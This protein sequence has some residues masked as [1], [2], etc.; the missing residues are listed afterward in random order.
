MY[1]FEQ[2][3]QF[4]AQKTN[5][6]ESPVQVSYKRFFPKHIYIHLT[7]QFF[8]HCRVCSLVASGYLT[9]K[10]NMR[11]QLLLQL[12]LCVFL[13]THMESRV[14]ILKS[15]FFLRLFTMNIFSFCHFRYSFKKFKIE[16]RLQIYFNCKKLSVCIFPVPFH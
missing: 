13:V 15:R 14:R 16:F 6:I 11:C 8:K 4:H 2:F 3:F 5:A 1:I 9:E 10:N 12:F 7:P